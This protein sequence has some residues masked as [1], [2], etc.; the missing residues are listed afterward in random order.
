MHTF[1]IFVPV[2][3]KLEAKNIRVVTYNPKTKRSSNMPKQKQQARHVAVI[4][5][6]NH[7]ELKVRAAMNGT[8]ISDLANKAIEVYLQ[9]LEEENKK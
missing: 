3:I 7:K 5:D 8:T 9:S 2:R 6:E 4:T 1:I